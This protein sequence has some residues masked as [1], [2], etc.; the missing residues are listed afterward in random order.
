MLI[1]AKFSAL[2]LAAMKV[3]NTVHI[4][5]DRLLSAKI[6]QTY[7]EFTTRNCLFLPGQ[8]SK[9]AEYLSHI[10][11]I[12]VVNKFIP[13]NVSSLAHLMQIVVGERVR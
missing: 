13:S 11:R 10:D 5:F 7:S 3:P 1:L 8:F 9:L 12:A 6:L 4:L 2:L